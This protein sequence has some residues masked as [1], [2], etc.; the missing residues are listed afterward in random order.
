MEMRGNEGMGFDQGKTTH[1][2]LLNKDGGAIQVTANAGFDTASIA[3]I[4]MHLGH[5][6]SAFKAGQ[7]QECRSC[8]GGT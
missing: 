4:R 5:I 6:R 3:H 7:Q 8:C 2:F 1:H